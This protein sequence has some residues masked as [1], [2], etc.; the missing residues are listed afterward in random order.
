MKYTDVI[1]STLAIMS[2]THMEAPTMDGL[3]R[4][5]QEYKDN[6]ISSMW[7]C[8]LT[9]EELTQKMSEQAE[10]D[11]SSSC[12]PAKASAVKSQPFSVQ[13]RGYQWHTPHATP[14]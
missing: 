7:A 11:R 1:R 12:T 9:V 2:W 6:L 5:L 14:A 8:V 10:T 13:G 4:Q 3:A